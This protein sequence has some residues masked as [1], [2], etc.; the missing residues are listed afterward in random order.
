MAWLRAFNTWGNPLRHIVRPGLASPGIGARVTCYSL[1]D[2]KAH[3]VVLNEYFDGLADDNPIGDVAANPYAW[4]AADLAANTQ[5]VVFVIGH[6]PASPQPDMA[7]PYKLRHLGDSLDA[8]P[9]TRDPFWN[10]LK[11]TGVKA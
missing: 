9:A 5:P 4:L 8:N 10:L 7:P 11:A 3:F 6:E 2:A 1:E